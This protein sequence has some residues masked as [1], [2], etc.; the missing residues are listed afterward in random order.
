[1]IPVGSVVGPIA[2]R[3]LRIIELIAAMR[4]NKAADFGVI[5]FL[6]KMYRP[7]LTQA[8]KAKQLLLR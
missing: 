7:A 5:V 8:S 3:T 4:M 6:L 2:N 1:L